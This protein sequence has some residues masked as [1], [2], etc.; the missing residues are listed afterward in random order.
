MHKKIQQLN[1]RVCLR[2]GLQLPFFANI[3]LSYPQ[4]PILIA[5]DSGISS[6]SIFSSL[7]T[8][9]IS[10]SFLFLFPSFFPI[11]MLI[12]PSLSHLHSYLSLSI[13]SSFLSCLFEGERCSLIETE[14]GNKANML[15]GVLADIDKQIVD[16]EILIREKER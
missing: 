1:L 4:L 12:S 5:A 16:L 8:P 7:P 13:P 15:A 2:S 10:L 11:F 6:L 9:L 3:L 14:A